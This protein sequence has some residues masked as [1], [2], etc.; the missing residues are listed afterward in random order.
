MLK[1]PLKRSEKILVILFAIALIA[2]ILRWEKVKD[3][4]IRGWKQYDIV[5]WFSRE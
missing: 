4:F 2:V 1:R 5:E 3:G